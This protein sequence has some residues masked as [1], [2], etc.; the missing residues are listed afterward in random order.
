MLTNTFLMDF[1]GYYH[2]NLMAGAPEA[3]FSNYIT[4]EI[5]RLLCIFVLNDTKKFNKYQG[6][7]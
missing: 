7:N 4:K 2:H 5:R 1:G 3:K 6:S